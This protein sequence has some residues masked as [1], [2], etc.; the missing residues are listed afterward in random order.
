M[1]SMLMKKRMLTV[2]MAF[3]VMVSVFTG[4][5]LNAFADFTNTIVRPYGVQRSINVGGA[6]VQ[7]NTSEE[8]SKFEEEYNNK[9]DKI[10]NHSG[11]YTE[12]GTSDNNVKRIASNQKDTQ[13]G[14]TI[15][16]KVK[17]IDGKNIYE[18]DGEWELL[19]RGQHE[20]GFQVQSYNASY[21]YVETFRYHL[22][23][24]KTGEIIKGFCIDI[25]ADVQYGGGYIGGH[26]ENRAEENYKKYADKIR[27]IAGVP[28]DELLQVLKDKYGEDSEAYANGV[29]FIIF[30]KQVL[31][32]KYVH[33]WEFVD[34]DYN[35]NTIKYIRSNTTG[36]V[37][38]AP[39]DYTD[40]VL[41]ADVAYTLIEYMD[42]LSTAQPDE[43]AA[44]V[45]RIDNLVNDNEGGFNNIS[46]DYKVEGENV[47]APIFVYYVGDNKYTEDGLKALS[48]EITITKSGNRIVV[49]IPDSVMGD[50]DFG[51]KLSVDRTVE[52]RNM[53]IS[54]PGAHQSQPIVSVKPLKSNVSYEVKETVGTRRQDKTFDLSLMKVDSAELGNVNIN[55]GLKGALFTL[56]KHDGT[57]LEENKEVDADGKV[58]FTGLREGAYIITEE[59]APEGYDKVSGD[60][61][62]IVEYDGTIKALINGV[63][64]TSNEFMIPVPNTKPIPPVPGGKEL[65]GKIE[66]VVS[67]DG[68]KGTSEKALTVRNDKIA[69]ITVIK[70]T[71]K[72]S[73]L[74]GG[75]E[76]T[77]KGSL[78]RI[79]DGNVAETVAEV[80]ET[81]TAE[82][83][84]AGEW[85]MEFSVNGNLI[86]D[87]KYVVYEEAVSTK[88]LIDSDKDNTPDKPQKVEHKDPKAVTQTILTGKPNGFVKIIK[89]DK[90]TNKAIGGAVFEIYKKGVND[91]ELGDFVQEIT[92][93]KEGIKIELPFGAYIAVEKTAPEG[94]M[95]SE[96]KSERRSAFT[97]VKENTNDEPYELVVLNVKKPNTP[98]T[99]PPE[100][101]NTPPT[102]PDNPNKPPVPPTPPTPPDIPYYPPNITPDPKEPGSPN[103]FIRVDEDGTP[104]GRYKKQKKN[105]EYEYVLD[106]DGI[107]KGG[108]RLPS[109][110]G[111]SAK[112]YYM[113]GTMLLVLAAAFLTKKKN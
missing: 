71:I 100:N 84:G 39:Y 73:G 1:K 18:N 83:S 86:P 42:G 8:A 6:K 34:S 9:I 104:Q 68:N 10:K 98:P 33:S 31:I 79:A 7:V 49:K 43:G 107:P 28:D 13:T 70:D 20:V 5:A 26:I 40:K 60:I 16:E 47:S 67:I 110:G 19:P 50:K 94:Y 113:C 108:L 93:P 81:K 63:M 55:R 45:L 44:P 88:L 38:L 29:K 62:V 65:K 51:V 23:S 97:L 21:G 3:A 48:P 41:G 52:K 87:A 77:V 95:L 59:K 109:T 72:Y 103:E 2:V 22:K 46:F 11:V 102:P 27:T 64:Y 66:T 37:P 75:E 99:P 17:D 56:K 61:K 57:V 54:K 82:A 90:D 32:W 85:T 69:E 4:N 80:T 111:E 76:Y 24:T 30:V 89:K 15:E 106:E 58:K 74:V 78:N 96:K 91:N 112:V 36:T 25:G 53:F 12:R 35:G 101:P 14:E 105:G 92:I